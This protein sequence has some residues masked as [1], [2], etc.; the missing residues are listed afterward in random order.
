MKIALKLGSDALLDT[1][2]GIWATVNIGWWL[3]YISNSVVMDA[4]VWLQQRW[5]DVR[6]TGNAMI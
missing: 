3:N 4:A 2:R 5:H 6:G 1:S